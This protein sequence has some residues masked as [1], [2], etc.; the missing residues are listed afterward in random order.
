MA[1]TLGFKLQ[2]LAQKKANIMECTNIPHCLNSSCGVD[3]LWRVTEMEDN[4]KGTMGKI[5]DAGKIGFMG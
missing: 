2:H 5:T 3:Q 1:N 4:E